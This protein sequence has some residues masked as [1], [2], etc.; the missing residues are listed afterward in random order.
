LLDDIFSGANMTREHAPS[1]I[2]MCLD[3]CVFVVG[4]PIL[5]AEN[6][7]GNA[8]L[9]QVVQ[10]AA[11]SNARYI[12]IRQAGRPASSASWRENRDTRQRCPPV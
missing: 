4:Q 5:L 9:A 8:D 10:E 7:V 1:D 3:H 11:D 12:G 2:R 6:V